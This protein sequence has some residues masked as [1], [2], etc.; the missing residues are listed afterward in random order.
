MQV[1]SMRTQ[2][3]SFDSVPD[4]GQRGKFNLQKVVKAEVGYYIDSGSSIYHF[5]VRGDE[6]IELLR[7][8]G[9]PPHNQKGKRRRP[10]YP[11][12]GGGCVDVACNVST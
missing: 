9:A 4:D 6:T 10:G 7:Y 12:H 1:V 8:L 2:Q 5:L 11:L 3:V